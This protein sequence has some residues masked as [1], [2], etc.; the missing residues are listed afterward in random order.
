MKSLKGTKTAENLMKAFAGESQARNRYTYYASVAKKEGYVQIANL[1]TE[2]ADNEKEHAKRFFKFLVESLDGEMVEINASYP[3]ALGDTKANL[4]AAAQGE[5][6]EWAELYPHFADV[7]EEEG[8]PAIAVVFRK[9]ADVEKHHEARY[10]KLYNNLLN[11]T[12]FKKSST[13]QWKC[14]NCGYIHEGETAPQICPACAHPQG[15]F[16]VFVET[17]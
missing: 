2:T 10:R 3:V 8:F 4:L 14:N 11:D 17:Y 15:F 16:E 9:I 1:F 12:V 6:E 7:A 13:V 5:N